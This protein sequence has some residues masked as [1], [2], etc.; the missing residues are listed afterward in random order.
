MQVQAEHLAFWLGIPENLALG[1]ALNE[2]SGGIVAQSA[3]MGFLKILYD[4]L[5]DIYDAA[6]DEL[7]EEAKQSRS[8]TVYEH[9]DRMER[10][11][12]DRKS[13]DREFGG[14]TMDA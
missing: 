13:R 3:Y 6:K 2:I 10:Y 14:P 9:Y 11:I 12:E 5:E 1:V 7:Q 4:K 8:E